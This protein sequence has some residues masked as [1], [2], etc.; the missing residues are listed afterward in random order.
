[1]NVLNIVIGLFLSLMVARVTGLPLIY[2]VAIVA[3]M[4]MM[5]GGT[6]GGLLAGVTGVV[7]GTAAFF[8]RLLVGLFVFTGLTMIVCRVIDIPPGFVTGGFQVLGPAPWNWPIL[9]LPMLLT[10]SVEFLVAWVAM[11]AAAGDARIA[12]MIFGASALVIF[13]IMWAAPLAEAVRPKPVNPATPIPGAS[14]GWAEAVQTAAERGTI[15]TIFCTVWTWSWGPD[16]WPCRGKRSEQVVYATAPVAD[17]EPA[18]ETTPDCEWAWSQ[19]LD[20]PAEGGKLSLQ[21]GWKIESIDG[22]L[23]IETPSGKV[24]REEPGVKNSVGRQPDGV[25]TLKSDPPGQARK[26]KIYNCWSPK[27]IQ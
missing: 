7:S 24:L 14:Q 19:P 9:G 8:K 15:P 13:T 1:M 6:A 22:V 20:I 11:R 18:K 4:W 25:Y 27:D 23:N 21:S 5:S 16:P 12:G 17:D 10:I 3:A 2:G 26:V